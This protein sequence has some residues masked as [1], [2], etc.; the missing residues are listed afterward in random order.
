MVIRPKTYI[1]LWS[2]VPL[3]LSSLPSLAGLKTDISVAPA[4]GWL[5]GRPQSMSY[6]RHE[7]NS[8]WPTKA[9]N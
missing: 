5:A 7:A 1:K 2:G 6:K 4:A 3:A 8:I 9:A